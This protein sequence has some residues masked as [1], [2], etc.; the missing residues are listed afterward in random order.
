MIYR[1]SLLVI[2][3]LALCCCRKDPATTG[4]LNDPSLEKYLGYWEFNHHTDIVEWVMAFDDEGEIIA[5][6]VTSHSSY[7]TTGEV[8]MGRQKGELG[9]QFDIIT[10]NFYYAD[11]LND[12]GHLKCNS[13][14]AIIGDE[15]GIHDINDTIYRLDLG[16][17]STGGFFNKTTSWTVEGFPL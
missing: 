11:V 12:E 4:E 5:E 15:G 2:V 16:S 1:F 14:C 8:F 9:I 13:G 3:C 6:M 7:K 10:E 17:T